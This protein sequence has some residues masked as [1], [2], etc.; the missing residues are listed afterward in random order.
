MYL[1]LLL[2]ATCRVREAQEDSLLLW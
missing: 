1:F 2:W